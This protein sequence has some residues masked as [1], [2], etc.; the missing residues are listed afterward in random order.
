[1]SRESEPLQLVGRHGGMAG[2]RV[3]AAAWERGRTENDGEKDEQKK[4]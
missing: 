1:M 4:R 2:S 3:W